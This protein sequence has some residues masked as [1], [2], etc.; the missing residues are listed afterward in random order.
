MTWH[1]DGD[2]RH[3]NGKGQ[4]GNM[5][6]DNGSR[7]TGGTAM[8]TIGTTRWHDDG[9]GRNGND[10]GQQG[11]RRQDDGDRRYNNWKT[12]CSCIPGKWICKY[13]HEGHDGPYT[14]RTISSSSTCIYFY[15]D[16]LEI[17]MEVPVLAFDT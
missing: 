15:F 17:F 14:I 11:N 8:A 4:H 1:D 6:H 16:L 10:N 12:Y 13:C 9:Y 7:A 3:N 2:G 5:R